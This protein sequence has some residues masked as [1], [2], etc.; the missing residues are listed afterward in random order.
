MGCQ[1]DEQQD[2]GSSIPAATDLGKGLRGKHT[3]GMPGSSVQAQA[4]GFESGLTRG[5]GSSIAGMLYC[6]AGL[7]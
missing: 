1:R 6:M 2:A 3:A 7:V 4:R 5:R